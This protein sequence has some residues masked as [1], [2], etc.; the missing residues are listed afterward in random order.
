MKLKLRRSQ[1]S[2]ITGTITFSLFFIIDP[3]PEEAAAIKRYKLGKQIVY[4]TPKGAAASEFLRGANSL[5]E[6]GKGLTA[7]IAAKATSQIL[8]VNDLVN[9]KEL[10]CKDIAEMIATEEQIKEACQTLSQIL[11]VSR[12]FEGEEL[13]EI[14]PLY[15]DA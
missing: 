9:G 6:I 11:H 13:I 3:S 7:T 1:K 5:R 2:G 10:S 15:A 4:E 8:T 12:H 14:T